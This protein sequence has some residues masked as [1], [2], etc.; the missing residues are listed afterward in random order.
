MVKIE[1]ENM[2]GLIEIAEVAGVGAPAVSNWRER[3]EDFPK[4]IVEVS[5]TPIFD[6]REIHAWLE[7]TGRLAGYR[8]D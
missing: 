2:I 4:P 6:F 3:H 8:Y 5:G 1:I 7:R